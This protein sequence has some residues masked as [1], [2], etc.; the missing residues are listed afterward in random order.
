[1]DSRDEVGRCQAWRLRA[2]VHWLQADSAAAEDA[3]RQAAVHA[4]LAGD[5]RQLTEVLGWLA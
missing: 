4:R 3:W 2:A 5:E 1:V